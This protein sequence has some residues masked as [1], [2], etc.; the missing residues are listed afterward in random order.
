MQEAFG[1]N[2]RCD[3]RNPQGQTA[4][5]G[6]RLSTM[7]FVPQYPY[8]VVGGLEKQAHELAKAL[9]AKGVAVQVMSGRVVA[10]QADQEVVEGVPVTRLPWSRS[11]WLRFVL[12]P[13]NIAHTLWVKR[14]EFD[15]IH[16]HQVS[17]ASLFIIVLAGLMGK[18]VLVKL[19]NVG[20]YGIPGLQSRWFGKL[21]LHILLHAD[22][23]VAM[24]DESCRELSAA[25]FPAAR[26]LRT[27]NGIDLARVP[28]D[29]V[30]DQAA[31]GMCRVVFVGRLSEEKQLEVLLDAW[32]GLR[33]DCR[34]PKV[35]HL[36]GDGPL[37]PALKVQAARLGLLDSVHFH[38]QVTD[39]AECLQEMDV[40]VITSRVEGNSNAVLE[41]MAA[42]LPIVATAVGG[43]PMQ[44][45]EAGAPFLCAA[46]DVQA[47][48][49]AL[50]R[51]IAD[52]SLRATVGAAMRHR[53]EQHFD[54]R[55][56]AEVYYQ[57]YRCLAEGRAVDVW[58]VGHPILSLPGSA[59]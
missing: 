46:G 14:Y 3:S 53:A 18:R 1:M 58:Q 42:G 52:S 13:W 55:R 31:E 44:V 30:H 2:S 59:R 33:N 6:G 39:V 23:I 54:I 50:R 22:V 49:A 15:V 48:A 37:A 38:G 17:P 41:A 12:S 9:L 24:S 27:P 57:A 5:I 40:F 43:T 21:R 51:L 26:V 4:V 8:P 47:L 36:L 34:L 35:L 10:G 25:G 45:G 32:H 7:M 16:L 20:D 56:V 19:A 28:G 29:R 11:R